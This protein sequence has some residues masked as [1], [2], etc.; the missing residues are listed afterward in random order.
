VDGLP[1]TPLAVVTGWTAV[2]VVATFAFICGVGIWDC[3]RTFK[4]VDDV[5]PRPVEPMDFSNEIRVTRGDRR[6]P[7]PIKH[8][9]GKKRVRR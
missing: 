8:P 2:A 6:G 1:V 9:H 4:R 7:E 3:R 5:R